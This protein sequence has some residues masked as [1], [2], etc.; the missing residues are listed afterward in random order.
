MMTVC[1]P[2]YDEEVATALLN[3]DELELYHYDDGDWNN[4]TSYLDLENNRICGQPQAFSPFVI[5]NTN[6]IP[7]PTP[8]YDNPTPTLGP[9][10]PTFTP[11]P[12][13][14]LPKSGITVNTVVMTLTILFLLGL[15]VFL[16]L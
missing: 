13:G 1:L 5:G 12:T 15:G 8:D 11:T 16:L 6:Y 14:L 9:N 2:Y 3:E 10:D 7:S 4:I